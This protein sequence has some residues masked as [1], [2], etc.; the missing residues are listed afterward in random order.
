MVQNSRALL[1]TPASPWGASFGAQQ[2]TALVYDALA[3]LMPVDVLLLGEGNENEIA[4]GDRP[5]ILARIS[6]KQPPLTFYKYGV[7]KWAN[8]WCQ[9]NIDWSK[10]ALVVGREFTSIT[11][12]DWPAHM[13]TIA[14]CDD[15][16][17]R[18]TPKTPSTMDRLVA[19]ARG[20]VRFWQTRNAI[21]K[22]DHAFF[23][24]QRDRSLFPCRYSSILPNVARI[25]IEKPPES[26]DATGT[27]LIVGSM[28]Y[29]PNRQGLEWFLEH[30]WPEVAD[31]CPSLVLRII[32]SAPPQV[33]KR[34]EQ[35]VRVEA[36][37][38]VD[39]L[40]AEYAGASFAL[41][42]IHYGGGTCIKFLEAAAFRKACVVTGYVFEGFES[43]F[44]DGHSVLVA[45]D[46]RSM[47]EQCVSLHED[48]GRRSAIAE[49]A[50]DT[51]SHLYTVER[52]HATVQ[53]AA[54][55]LM[56]AAT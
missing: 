3:Q 50:Y 15:A 28:W 32:G 11:K 27:A 19:S 25:P 10:Y 21:K 42:P 33:R 8:D 38:F 13:R 45:R 51:V 56:A 24:T 20:K 49:R 55:R 35:G 30:C 43:D 39:D 6:W 12:V 52:F 18:Y 26:T 5:E 14:D 2:R 29:A 37:G 1:V 23:C 40:H 48:A 17:Y 9:A 4:A 53:E 36:P 46:P 41:A 44:R 16:Y 7:N 31:R 22:Y 34:W 54:R 47:V